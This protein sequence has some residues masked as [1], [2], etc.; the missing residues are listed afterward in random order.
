MP[1]G[2]KRPNSGRKRSAIQER[3][4]ELSAKIVVRAERTGITPLEYLLSI[5]RDENEK[6]SARLEAAWRAAPY[7]HPKLNAIH[8][9]GMF[10]K[11]QVESAFI[12]MRDLFLKHVKDEDAKI[13]L[14]QEIGLLIGQ[15][16]KPA[17]EAPPTGADNT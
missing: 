9:T 6:P 7:M 4:E 14:S 5:M 10:D 13:A 15:E 11:M 17:A 2:G 1:R 8:H 16:L 3:A 12:V